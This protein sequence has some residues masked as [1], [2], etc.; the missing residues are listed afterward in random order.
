M[1]LHTYLKEIGLSQAEF[2]ESL[3]PPASQGLVS[4]WIRG[5]T[6]VTLYYALQIDAKTGGKVSPQDSA[7]MYMDP[8]FCDE[9]KV[10]VSRVSTVGNA[11]SQPSHEGG[12]PSS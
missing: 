8:S 10:Q 2:G 3:D 1:H 9:P 7:D 12:S 6:R 4:Q 11:I 5:V